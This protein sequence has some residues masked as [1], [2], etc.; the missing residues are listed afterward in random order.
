MFSDIVLSSPLGVEELDLAPRLIN[1]GLIRGY[2]ERDRNGAA[3]VVDSYGLSEGSMF[4]AI[5]WICLSRVML[6]PLN[7]IYPWLAYS[8]S[9]FLLPQN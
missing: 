9:R 7:I 8:S 6:I 1:S 4:S 3:F 5:D 2:P